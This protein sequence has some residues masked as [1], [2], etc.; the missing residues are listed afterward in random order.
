MTHTAE[1]DATPPE[2][3]SMLNRFRRDRLLAR[4][5]IQSKLILMLV[6]CTMLAAA[7]VGA[8]AFE[9]G[10]TSL[11]TAVFTRLIEIRE[12]QSRAL[13]GEFTDLK[14]SLV[15][16]SRGSSTSDA[17]E[18]FT[19]G[20][21]QLDNAAVSPA[22]WQGILDYYNTFIEQTS[23]QSGTQLDAAALLPTTPA[24]RYLQANYTARLSTPDA[25]IAMDNAGDGSQWSAANGRYQEFF[26]QIVTRFG[27]QDA[28]LLDGRGNVVYSAYKGV[29]LGTNIVN[30]PY[31]GS[32]LHAAY[33]KAMSANTVDYVGLT[34]FEFYQPAQMQPT[35][36][37]VAPIAPN[38]RTEGVL[39]LQ[40]PISKINQ[41]MTFDRKWSDAGLGHTGETFLVGPDGLMRSNSRVFVEDPQRYKREVTA[42]GTPAEVADKAILLGGT[43]LVQPDVSEATSNARRGETGTLVSD[44]YLGNR[45]LQSYAPLPD[46]NSG[47][48]W[49]IVA[50]VDAAEA[51]AKE[52]SFTRT[53][54]LSTVG[55]I[56]I[57]CVLAVYLAQ[58]FVRPIRKLEAGAQRIAAGDYSVA[59][60]VETRDEL[61][62]LTQAFNDM[63]RSLTVKDDLL[64]EQRRQNDELLRS[65]MPE[66]VIERFRQGEE[67][68]ATEH[69]NVTVIFADLIGLDRLQSE[70]SPADY[71]ALGNELIRQIDAA[72][73]DL[74]VESVHTVRNGYLASC[75]LTV[76]R[77]DNVSRTAE[78]ALECE[79]IVERFNSDAGIELS[80][81]AGIDTGDVGS[82]LMGS[83]SV[84]YDMWGDAVNLAHQVKNG[85][86]RPGIYVTARVYEALR[87]T[88]TFTEA[89]TVTVDG[90]AQPIWQAAEDRS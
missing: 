3:P 86:P 57:V 12:A 37:M 45:A 6:L 20:F 68:I 34:D 80:L 5:S 48:Q 35:A 8:I 77:L 10:R 54:V 24:Q 15:I 16:Y 63:S 58:V 44:D 28:L 83:P 59:V 64:T 85:S 55:M 47:L 73:T 90:V 49:S 31:A 18:A 39:A 38:G 26:R 52:S 78:F 25:A 29:D 81:R 9:V 13:E 22:Q 7:V 30:G 21:D 17:L 50:K 1:Q 74:G 32:K 51:F 72:A 61:G 27:F 4:I 76:P 11:R 19:A 2:K 70:L 43:T 36:W 89:G 41:L 88:M 56:F 40:F 71:L 53:M 87:D 23:K 14:N 84:V 67:T 65:L 69:H 46:H 66:T 33:L 75:G 79:R 82:G 60:P 62:D 42:A